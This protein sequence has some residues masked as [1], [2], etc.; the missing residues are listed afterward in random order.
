MVPSI[1]YTE[2]VDGVKHHFRLTWDGKVVRVFMDG[3]MIRKAT[4]ASPFINTSLYISIMGHVSG[5]GS[6]YPY[7]VTGEMD[8]F[9][10]SASC[11]NT[12]D[13]AFEVPV[14]PW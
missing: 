4:Q 3:K 11:L 13:D 10:F 8:E 5:A 12:T 9:M 6:S 1:P 14:A 2:Y 7:T